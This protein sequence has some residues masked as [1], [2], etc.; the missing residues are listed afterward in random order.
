MLDKLRFSVP[1][2]FGKLAALH[3]NFATEFWTGLAPNEEVPGKM[4]KR[5]RNGVKDNVRGGEDIR[6]SKPER[7]TTAGSRSCHKLKNYG[8]ESLSS[9]GPSACRE[10]AASSRIDHGRPAP[11]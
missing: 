11:K 8:R 6:L 9:I 4:E 1:T 7:V 10:T 3:W 2:A 5:L